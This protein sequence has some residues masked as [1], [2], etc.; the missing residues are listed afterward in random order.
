MG[1]VKTLQKQVYGKIINSLEKV[2]PTTEPVSEESRGSMLLNEE[3]HLQLAFYADWDYSALMPMKIKAEGA[4]APY[5]RFYKEK[6]VPFTTMKEPADDYYIG[7]NPCLLP[8]PLWNMEKTEFSLSDGQWRAVWVTIRLPENV[9]SGVYETKFTLQDENGDSFSVLT[10]Q[11]EVIGAKL[12]ETPLC[13]TNWLYCDCIAERHS[14]KP[15]SDRFYRFFESYLKVYTE[16]GYNMLLTPLFTP[17]LDTKVGAERLTTQLVK[18]SLTDNRYEFD[19]SDLK[20]YIEFAFAHGIKYI[21]F[22]HL[23]TQWGGKYCPKIEVFVKGRKRRMFGWNVC[24]DDPRYVA[25]LQSFLPALAEFI[26]EMGWRK[27]CYFH[28]TDEPQEQDVE[29]YQ[30]C[31]ELVR[32]YI[33]DM[34]IMDA[35]SHYAFYEKGLVD[36]PAVITSSYEEFA[37]HNVK[38]MLVYN[39]CLP[40]TE[41]Y[42]NR[43]LY[44]PHQRMRILGFQLYESGVQGYLHWGY[45]FYNTCL[46]Y[47]RGIDP[48]SVTDSGGQ[49]PSGDGFL[50]YPTKNGACPS[51]RSMVGLEGFQD[52]RAMVLLE[53]LIGRSETLRILHEQGIVGYKT[54][55]RDANAHIRFREYINQIIK[56]H[57]EAEV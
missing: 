26:D 10:H 39:C 3:Y 17:P 4:L 8:D 45:N 46:S 57:I 7:G 32:G 5:I 18:V 27:R 21:E 2:L 42:S 56:K 34:P 20:K 16:S 53:S 35:L 31:A 24:S 28:L 1:R 37:P 48:Y 50:V 41:Y 29:A 38:D 55:K 43:F 49:F 54:Y 11:I 23:F 22:S 6:L 33:G 51:I 15:F 25:F 12:P 14:A 44:S 52:Y 36:T 19:F 47:E 13:L 40:T 9:Q 30:K